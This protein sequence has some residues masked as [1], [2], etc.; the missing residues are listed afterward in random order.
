MLFSFPDFLSDDADADFLDFLDFFSSFETTEDLDLFLDFFLD[1]DD[2][3]DF[4]SSSS[5]PD[6][7]FFLL[8][9][10]FFLD[11]FSLGFLQAALWAE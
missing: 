2:V 4:S 7:F 1:R 11:F 3:T 10:L 9:D 5:S 6:F 8:L